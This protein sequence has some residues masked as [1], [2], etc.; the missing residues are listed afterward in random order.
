MLVLGQLGKFGDKQSTDK[1][2]PS[3]QRPVMTDQVGPQQGTTPVKWGEEGKAT[4][5][6]CSAQRLA[7]LC[8]PLSGEELQLGG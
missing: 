5:S 4:W 3:Q 8:V 6:G 7:I 1:D 2:I